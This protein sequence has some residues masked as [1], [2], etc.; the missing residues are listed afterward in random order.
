MCCKVYVY[1]KGEKMNKMING[2]RD[3][4]C[5]LYGV[6]NHEENLFF[7]PHSVSAAISLA[8][9]GARGR[10]AT[11]LEEVLGYVPG[12]Q[13]SATE[14]IMSLAKTG[15]C[16]KIRL[17]AANSAWLQ[18]DYPILGEYRNM[19][20]TMVR[21]TDFSLAEAAAKAINVWVEEN[22]NNLIHDLVPADALNSLTRL[23][24]ANAIHFKGAW[25]KAFDPKRTYQ[26]KFYCL[27]GSSSTTD[28]MSANK[29]SIRKVLMEGGTAA[30]LPYGDGSMHMLVI[31]PSDFKQYAASFDGAKFSRIQDALDATHDGE[32]DVR[33]PKFKIESTLELAARLAEL[34]ASDAFVDGVADFSGITGDRELLISAVLHKALVDVSE[35]GTEAA[36][37]TAVVMRCLSMSMTESFTVN[38][39]FI[40]AICLKE[41]APLFMGQVVSL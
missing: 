41:G 1:R 23:V 29:L 3:F 21:E 10:T 8:Y 4:A 40:F 37:A 32:V 34:G 36:A 24:L 31:L 6:L 9:A 7:S 17:S 13:T 39:P 26:D 27:D 28:M 11:Q 15:S 2:L 22:T 18:K 25:T 19:L 20:G 5:R 12:S 14:D 30:R 33:M 38:R 16:D 35:E